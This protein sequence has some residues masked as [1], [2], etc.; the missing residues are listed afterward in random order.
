MTKQVDVSGHT[1][2]GLESL[3]PFQSAGETFNVWPHPQNPGFNVTLLAT[4]LQKCGYCGDL[5]ECEPMTEEGWTGIDMKLRRKGRP[6][7][8]VRIVD[9][10]EEGYGGESDNMITLTTRRIHPNVAA[11]HLVEFFERNGHTA[12]WQ[13]VSDGSADVFVPTLLVSG[14]FNILPPKR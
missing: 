7:Q 2:V 1:I 5:R 14:R 8:A 6:R 9:Y 3:K 4:L 10:V 13:S 12:T 11:S